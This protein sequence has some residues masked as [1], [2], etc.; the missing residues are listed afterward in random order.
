MI[1]F[2]LYIKKH[3]WSYDKKYYKLS[4]YFLLYFSRLNLKYLK[5]TKLDITRFAMKLFICHLTF[6]SFFYQQIIIT[7]SFFSLFVV[8]NVGCDYILG[9]D[10]KPDACGVCH[11]DNSTCVFVRGVYSEQH[12]RNGKQPLP[13]PPPPPH[14]NFFYYSKVYIFIVLF[15]FCYCNRTTSW[16]IKPFLRSQYMYYKESTCL[17]MLAHLHQNKTKQ[18]YLKIDETGLYVW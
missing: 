9:S 18:N 3:F 7:T 8:Q 10:S 15:C 4:H 1:P 17:L 16:N 2:S 11:G 5:L 13:P 14:I 12:D 6:L